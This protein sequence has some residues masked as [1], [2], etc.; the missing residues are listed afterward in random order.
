MTSFDDYVELLRRGF[1][2]FNR[3]DLDAAFEHVT[4]DAVWDF[5]EREMNPAVLHGPDAYRR[6]YEAAREVWEEL[7]L[8]P[9]EFFDAGDRIVVFVRQRGRGRGSGMEVEELLASVFTI[10]DGK[11][12][13]MRLYRDRERALR[14]AGL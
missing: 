7:R 2:A 3:G 9:E 8:E 13:S 1:A 12:T 14:D 4:P 5:S 6:D 10:A 11:V